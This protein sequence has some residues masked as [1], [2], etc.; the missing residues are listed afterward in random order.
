[1]ADIQEHAFRRLTS[2]GADQHSWSFLVLAALE[3]DAALG[4]FLSGTGAF[5]VPAPPAAAP[6]GPAVEPPGAFVGAITV[7]G[8]RGVGPATTLPLHAGPGLTL[9]VGRNGSGKSSFAEGLELLLTGDNLRWKN[10][11]QPWKLGWRNLHQAQATSLQT[12]D[13]CPQPVATACYNGGLAYADG[14]PNLRVADGRVCRRYVRSSPAPRRPTRR[15][16]ERAVVS[17]TR[18]AAMMERR[19]LRRALGVAVLSAGL[20]ATGVATAQPLGTFRWQTQPFCNVLTLAV[21]QVGAAYRLEGTDDACGGASTSVIGMAAVNGGGTVGIGLTL[22]SP[23][24]I[25]LTLDASVNPAAGFNGTWRDSVGRTGTL[26]LVSGPGLGGPVRPVV[27]PPGSYGTTVSQPAGAVDRG[28]SATVTTDT[29]AA[30]DAAGLYGRFGAPLA[31]GPESPAGV[32]GESDQHV[33]VF[34]RTSFGVGVHGQA[35]SAGGIGV[36]ASHVNGGTALS[37]DNGAIRVTGNVRAAFSVTLPSAG[38]CSTVNHVLLNNDPNALVFVTTRSSD[39]WA[40]ATYGAAGPGLWAIC[41]RTT[42]TPSGSIQV[43]VLV[44]KG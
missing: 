6:A 36:Q 5:R 28:F 32:R 30:N 13:R 43:A 33:G 26:L 31:A 12:P 8:F 40:S 35:A 20:T 16:P 18:G 7:S 4:G 22:V 10:R 15:P 3:G 29:G 44:I 37:L 25:P 19:R 38:A 21:T 1:M 39:Y 42:G 23:G 27:D 14:A 34:G 11:A 24:A 17:S 2:T 41:T 9:V